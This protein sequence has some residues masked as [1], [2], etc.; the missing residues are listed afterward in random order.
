MFCCK[1][2]SGGSAAALAAGCT[3]LATGS[4]IGGSIRIPAGSCGVVGYK[5]PYGRNPMGYPYNHDPYCVV[6]PLSRTV[7]DCAI[8]QNV[9]CG[10]NEKDIASLRPKKILPT[11]YENI[12]NWKIAYSLECAH[13]LKL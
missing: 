11:K 6:G 3:T 5:P 8:M 1:R 13:S 2:S 4:D 12:K 10:P 7:P 9:M